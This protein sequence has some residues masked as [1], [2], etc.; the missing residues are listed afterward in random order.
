MEER[1]MGRRDDMLTPDQARAIVDGAVARS[2]ELG[3]NPIGVAVSDSAGYLVAATRHD[4]GPG[5]L[6]DAARG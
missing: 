3:T 5:F 1:S 2:N 6:V 4:G